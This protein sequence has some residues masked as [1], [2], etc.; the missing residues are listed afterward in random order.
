MAGEDY[1]NQKIKSIPFWCYKLYLT[2]V[3]ASG[4]IQEINS[5]EKI[6]AIFYVN[7]CGSDAVLPPLLENNEIADLNDDKTWKLIPFDFS[8]KR[9]NL[10]EKIPKFF[11][12][13]FVNSAIY[14]LISKKPAYFLRF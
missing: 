8:K 10:K 1:K 2:K 7:I 5:N 12:D 14:T 11:I 6:D 4:K 3:E 9:E 13:M